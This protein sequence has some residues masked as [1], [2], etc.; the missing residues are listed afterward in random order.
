MKEVDVGKYLDILS[1]LKEAY[2]T[3]DFEY[4]LNFK[5]G[6]DYK[7]LCQISEG[8]IIDLRLQ[9]KEDIIFNVSDSMSKFFFEYEGATF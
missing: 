4:L 3:D 1:E 8:M 5:H 2:L 6:K 9:V 7:I